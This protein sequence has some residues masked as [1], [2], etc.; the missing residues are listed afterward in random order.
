[1]DFPVAQ[2]SVSHLVSSWPFTVS[3]EVP[4]LDEIVEVE[5]CLAVEFNSLGSESAA[6]AM[7]E[8]CN[9]PLLRVL[10]FYFIAF[11]IHARRKIIFTLF[12]LYSVM[13]AHWFLACVYAIRG[14]LIYGGMWLLV[15]PL[16]ETGEGKC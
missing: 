16:P 8:I 7:V 4:V 11:Y 2:M 10:L 14:S 5:L 6:G 13:F 15:V 3:S 12:R 9:H 1:M